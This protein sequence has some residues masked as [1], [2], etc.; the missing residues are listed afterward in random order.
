VI[1]FFHGD[2]RAALIALEIAQISENPLKSV[3]LLLQDHSLSLFHSLGKFLYPRK[4]PDP[5]DP[6]LLWPEDLG[7][8]NLY[9]HHNMTPGIL[10]ISSLSNVLS[11]LS[12][13]DLI[14]TSPKVPDHW[15]REYSA[16]PARWLSNIVSNF[17]RANCGQIKMTRPQYLDLKL[18]SR[19]YFR[20]E[21]NFG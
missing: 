6:V 1:E 14:E 10:K 15:K 20:D 4:K 2:L 19:A 9:L 8:F 17:D 16:L 7:L 21:K 11:V 3:D 5:Y 18:H 13:I 12:Q